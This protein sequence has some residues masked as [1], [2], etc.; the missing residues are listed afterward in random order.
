MR[1]EIFEL[2]LFFTL[3]ITLSIVWYYGWIKPADEMRGKIV[4]CMEEMNEQEYIRCYN[5]TSQ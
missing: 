2:V 4:Q 5:Q 3:L 1:N